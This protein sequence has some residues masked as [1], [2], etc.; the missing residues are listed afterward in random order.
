MFQEG[1]SEEGRLHRKCGMHTTSTPS[2]QFV[3]FWPYFS[4]E[5]MMS[6]ERQMQIH[7]LFRRLQL[8]ADAGFR[9][10]PEDTSSGI[11]LTCRSTPR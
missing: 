3:L 10:A 7:L 4:A 11:L 5:R 6:I 8:L 9:M 2:T 1:D